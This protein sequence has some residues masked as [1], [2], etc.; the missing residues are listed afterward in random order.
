MDVAETANQLDLNVDVI[1]RSMARVEYT[2]EIDPDM[3]QEVIDFMVSLGY[4]K[5]SFP[6]GD[7]LD[8]R[9]LK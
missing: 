5:S 4:I 3:V 2:T 6:A 7:I 8:L 1:L 9:F